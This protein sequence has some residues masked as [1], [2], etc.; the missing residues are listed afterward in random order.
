MFDPQELTPVTCSSLKTF[1]LCR[2]DY[3]LRFIRGLQGLEESEAQYLGSVMHGALE[4]WHGRGDADKDAVVAAIFDYIDVAFSSREQDERQKKD[5]HLARAMI[6]A[7]IETYP[8]EDFDVIA[9]E[10]QFQCPIINPDTGAASRSFYMRGKVDAL[11][12][13]NGE[14]FLLEHKTAAVIDKSYIE[15]LPLDFQVTLYAHYLEQFM[16]IR[17]AG[18]IYNVL[19]KSLIRQ[20]KGETEE[21]FEQRRAD[22]IAKSK[23]GKS[24]AKRK[25]P[26]TD[27][28]YSAR[29]AEKYREPGM[30]HR[31]MLYI[32][33]SQYETLTAEIWEL[34]QQL[35]IARRTSRWY[36]NTDVCFLYNRPCRFFPICVSGDNPNVIENRYRVGPIHPEL[37]EAAQSREPM[38][39]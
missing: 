25:L 5:W 35:L 22:L 1:K 11:V 21:E 27:D 20:S 36:M 2:K 6:T 34:S 26:E 32:P 38:F 14:Y 23:S 31:E 8:S 4:R 17:I 7:Y 28:E 24:S 30:F 15:K 9:V 19:A 18:V 13:R 33:R 39:T 10:K 16:N 3:N 29:L 12:M 37:D